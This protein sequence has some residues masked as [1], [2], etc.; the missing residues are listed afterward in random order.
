MYNR[1][2]WYC[3]ALALVFLVVDVM[4]R[5][6]Y[7]VYLSVLLRVYRLYYVA[8]VSQVLGNNA[9]VNCWVKLYCMTISLL[10]RVTSTVSLAILCNSGLKQNLK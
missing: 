8:F 4:L 2:C 5:L 10:T 6:T 9:A 1:Y 7:N 3:V